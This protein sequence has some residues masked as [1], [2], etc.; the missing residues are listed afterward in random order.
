MLIKALCDYYDELRK[1][2]KVFSDGYEKIKVNYV[3]CLDEKGRVVDILQNEIQAEMP[4]RESKST[5][6]SEIIEHRPE[7]IFGLDYDNN[8][9]IINDSVIKKHKKFVERNLEFIDGI[10]SNI[11]YAYK[12]FIKKWNPN[13]E[14]KNKLLVN[15][16]KDY[17]K[18]KLIF[19]L[20]KEPDK[21]LND[22][23]KVRE[24]WD[25]TLDKKDDNEGVKGICAIY[26]NKKIIARTHRK[27]KKIHGGQSTG[28]VLVGF[29]NDSECSYCNEQS[30]NS[31]ISEYAMNKYTEAL[32]YLTE[33]N[34]KMLDDINVVY[35][36]IDNKK[37]K[38]SDIMDFIDGNTNSFNGKEQEIENIIY[39]IFEKI[40]KGILSIENLNYGD[41]KGVFYIIGIKPNVSRLSIK[42]IYKNTIGK[43][44]ENVIRHQVDFKV[45]DDTKLVSLQQIRNE[46]VSKNSKTDALNPALTSKLFESIVNGYN[47]PIELLGSV[48]RRVKIDR[49]TEK[50]KNIRLN[51]IR[52]GIIKA[53]INRKCRK[54]N[55]KEEITMSLD[56]N[57]NNQ[58]YLCGRLFAV[59]EKIQESSLNGRGL[60]KTIKDSY[61]SSAMVK[62]ALVFPNL[63]RLS[64]YHIN[65]ID[66][67]G[68][69]VYVNKLIG[70]IID[71]LN[72]EFPRNLFLE[73][74]GRF[75]I[76]YYQQRQEFFKKKE[77]NKEKEE[78]KNGN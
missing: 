10:N 12:N 51:H 13:D 47:Y 67:D 75:V 11:A 42:F 59:L 74:Q 54:E 22:D 40:N 69:K 36:A 41:F 65:N 52:I 63:I 71:K 4:K 61:F 72:N 70:E 44:A 23:K 9:L 34:C 20:N 8:S 64:Q 78:E 55:K 30:F 29:N 16:G 31:N 15:M 45:K 6:N 43:V 57:N 18:A 62:P 32:N 76:G 21:F 50:D 68:S 56:Y 39:D 58:S 1:Q 25:K 60:N 17:K 5:V 33:K 53:Y 28:T 37:I 46:L 48:I 24:K 26:G 73:E 7:Y 27:I 77:D 38:E 19:C 3:I 66:K 49:D 14:V 35:F 2:G